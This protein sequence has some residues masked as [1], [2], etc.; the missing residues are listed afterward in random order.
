[1]GRISLRLILAALCTLGAAA[2][3]YWAKADPI[4]H[5]I[6]ARVTAATFWSAVARPLPAYRPSDI[7]VYPSQLG[8][9]LVTC[10]GHPDGSSHGVGKYLY[11]S[12]PDGQPT[13]EARLKSMN[14]PFRMPWQYAGWLQVGPWVGFAISAALLI[15]PGIVA[16]MKILADAGE[17]K[18]VAAP[19]GPV[20]AAP[21]SA[22]LEKLHALD[23]E[24]ERNL[25]GAATSVSSP[26]QPDQTP[27][28]PVALTG[29]PLEKVE[30]G[31]QEKKDYQGAYYPVA[32]PKEHGFSL[33]E[34]LV[35]IGVIGL[36]L[37]L[38]LPTLVAARRDANQIACEANLRSIGQGLAIYENEN[39]GCIPAAYSYLGQTIVNGKQTFSAAGG[40]T[41]WS[42]F[43]Y[44]S[45][46]T[47]LSAFLCPELENGGLP[48]TNTTPDNMLPGQI[49]SVYGVVDQQAPRVAYTLN[50]ALSPR[51]KF[52]VGFQGATRVYQFIKAASVP[53][54]SGTI[55]ATEWGPNAARFARAS[56]DSFSGALQSGYYLY[57][58][59]PI[60][61]F[62]GLDGTLDIYELNPS[63][64]YRRVT[65]ADLDADPNTAGSYGTLLDWVGRNH[66]K[67]TSYPNQRR[68]NFLY[69]D[70]HVECKSIYDTLQPFQWGD[71]F[72]TLKP[73]DDLKLQ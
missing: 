70:G 10:V 64:A 38:L 5:D 47:P 39:N 63:T 29:G 24:M 62:I 16:L 17:K 50:E 72:F 44:H 8:V 18:P 56:S 7:V 20:V 32:R 60:H 13:V 19:I 40:Y 23:A 48:P 51:N 9:Q 21:T 42:Y 35:V 68:S 30:E 45:G 4:P 55:L 6:S 61:G 49:A 12:T 3:L 14:I 66:G 31:P 1:M 54:S 15:W 69:V 33:V 2:I 46:S 43:L 28:A 59:R 67:P 65:A 71:T 36:L 22:D 41:H 25:T 34:L 73:N 58:H 53:N 11:V 27:A 26:S 57:S 37:A 52:T